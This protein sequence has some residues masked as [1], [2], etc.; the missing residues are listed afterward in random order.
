[1]R[2][3][4]VLIGMDPK[5]VRREHPA[6]NPDIRLEMNT[7]AKKRRRFGFLAVND[8]C[9]RENLGLIAD[10]GISGALAAAETD[11]HQ[12]QELLL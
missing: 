11:Y 8:D 7:F 12:P 3:A 4:S 6:D 5:T 2:R 1:M 9:C 10:T